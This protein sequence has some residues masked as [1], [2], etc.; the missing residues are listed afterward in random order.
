MCYTI[1][2]KTATKAHRK[3]AFPRNATVSYMKI[4]PLLLALLLCFTCVSSCSQKVRTD[5]P[6]SDAAA[7]SFDPTVY[8]ARDGRMRFLYDAKSDM[9]SASE[10]YDIA[11]LYSGT[12]YSLVFQY[13]E[14]TVSRKD[15]DRAIREEFSAGTMMK[16]SDKT[17]AVTVSG[18][19]FR[20]A[21]ITCADGSTG[22]V[23]YGSTETGYAKIYYLLAA[24]ADANTR[25][26][27]EEI[28]STVSFAEFEQSWD[29][30]DTKI[31]ID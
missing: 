27:V 8:Y 19:T 6:P 9:L 26:H 17:T 10:G 4:L 21:E 22:A 7:V 24:D 25:S 11:A 3:E 2:N 31:W 29:D 13:T 23:F 1:G 12:V 15:A 28:L 16:L 30:T 14:G 20:R 5:A 18:H